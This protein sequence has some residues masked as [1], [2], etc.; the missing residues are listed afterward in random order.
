VPSARIPALKAAFLADPGGLEVALT[1]LE[2]DAGEPPIA[3]VRD[4]IDALFRHPGVEA[5][6]EALRAEGSPWAQA[7]LEAIGRHSPTT[8]KVAFRQLGL[9]AGLERFED[10]MAMEY[11]LAVRLS[12]GHDFAEGV[13]AVLVDKDRNPKWS[14]ATLEA[15]DEKRLD[16]L[17]APL[18]D[19]EEWRPL[20]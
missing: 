12:A 6:V 8:M 9:S 2:G 19:E 3:L 4:R 16:A 11:R 7:Q 15:V 14:P 17:F 1:E 5:V 13:R 18:A 20:A 10:E